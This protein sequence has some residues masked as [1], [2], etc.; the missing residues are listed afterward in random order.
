MA[1]TSEKWIE[2]VTAY[3]QGLLEGSGVRASRITVDTG[4]TGT[5]TTP[6]A[7]NTGLSDSVMYDIYIST[8]S[9]SIGNVYQCT[10]GGDESTALWQYKFTI[11]TGAPGDDG[12]DAHVFFKYSAVSPT[13]DSDLTD[14]PSAYI[15]VYSG[16]ES[17]APSAWDSYTWYQWR[18]NNTFLKWSNTEPSQDSDLRDTPAPYIGFY[19]GSAV[20]APTTYA[21]YTWYYIKGE[22]GNGLVIKDVKADY[23]TLLSEIVNPAVG[24]A[25]AV[26]STV[27]YTIY[28]YLTSGWTSFGTLSAATAGDISIVDIG[29][30]YE[31]ATVEG[32][33]QEAGAALLQKTNLAVIAAGYS[34]MGTYALGVFC[35]NGGVFYECTTAIETAEEWTGAHW[36]QRDI[37]YVLKSLADAVSTKA[38][39]ANDITA[40]L[41]AA[42]WTGTEA[43]YTQTVAASGVTAASKIFVGLADTATDAQYTAALG[44]LLRATAQGVDSVT[45]TAIGALPETDIPVLIRIVG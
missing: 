36:T 28:I 26:G 4:I 2:L 11:P 21:S 16:M 20:S 34:N 32:A 40:M 19:V 27:P 29:G 30:F 45:I 43:P 42:S 14:N 44:A 17:S 24:D 35:I 5:S 13:Q 37:G 10:L 33:L 41:A 22:N 23:A 7:F 12:A 8:A 9:G 31:S 6:A 1:L 15:G 18:G 39:Q 25:Y 3:F 38:V